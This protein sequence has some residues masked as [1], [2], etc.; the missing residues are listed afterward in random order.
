MTD[1]HALERTSPKGQE[2]IGYC[3]KCGATDL[4]GKAVFEPC[5]N[6]AGLSQDAT[7][8]KAISGDV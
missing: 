2:F 1:T 6:P 3:I 4:P 5:P 7:L 8:L